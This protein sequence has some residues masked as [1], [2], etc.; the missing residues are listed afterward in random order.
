MAD[1]H[2]FG[3]PRQALVAERPLLQPPLKWAGGK[4]WL[5]P[6]IEK[7]WKVNP[8]KRLIEP[9]AGGLAITFGLQPD[10]ALVND[11]N[12][13]L[14]NFY[15]WL[16]TGLTISEDLRFGPRLYYRARDEFNALVAERKQNSRRAAELFFFLNRTCYNGL[17]RF[18]QNGEFNTPI[19]RYSDPSIERNL[20][21]YAA[22]MTNWQ[23]E[24]RDFSALHVGRG[25]FVFADPPYDGGF[26]DYRRQ[27]FSWNDQV[28][29]VS[30]LSNHTGP[31]IVSNHVTDRVIELYERNFDGLVVY[32]SR[33]AIT[34]S[35]R[36]DHAQEVVAYSNVNVPEDLAGTILD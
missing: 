30:F 3:M 34:S 13:H 9:F 7:F 6:E 36:R 25:D 16:S 12:P 20:T 19:G 33:R 11:N 18:N 8:S 35:A 21:R 15:R 2:W 22:A 14:M 26:A 5:L 1:L 28:R 23:I 31:V 24:Q 17:C 29:L 4:R 27:G 32:E 10:R